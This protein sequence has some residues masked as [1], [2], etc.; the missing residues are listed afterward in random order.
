MS[1]KNDRRASHTHRL[2]CEFN[3]IWHTT[4]PTR[5]D[6]L[7]QIFFG[8]GGVVILKKS[9][10]IAI[11]SCALVLFLVTISCA[12]FFDFENPEQLEQWEV[13]RETDDRWKLRNNVGDAFRLD[14]VDGALRFTSGGKWNLLAIK[15]LQFANGTIHY[16]LKWVEGAI[17]EIGIFYRLQE[18]AKLPHYQVQTSTMDVPISG[19]NW[20]YCEEVRW[21]GAIF[22]PKIDQIPLQ[23]WGKKPVNQWFEFK[24]EVKGDKHIISA[25]LAGK[26]EKVFEH[27]HQKSQNTHKG[28]VGLMSFSPGLETVLIDDLEV[29]SSVLTVEMYK[30]LTTTWGEIKENR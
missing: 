3:P 23:G 22:S 9:V 10:L 27:T 28:R 13:I 20:A 6:T 17:C 8:E 7:V 18:S 12:L 25:G 11:F 29:T 4:C 1:D 2:N 5:I 15:N 19:L 24:I 14:I 21:N 16:K 26:L 30:A